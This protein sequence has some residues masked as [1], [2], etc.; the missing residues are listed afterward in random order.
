M[1][2]GEIMLGAIAEAVFGYVIDRYGDKLGELVYD[3]LGRVPTKKAF[4]KALGEAF[5][6]FEQQYPE[7]VAEHFDASFFQREGAPIL[8]QFLIRDGHPDPIELAACWADSLSIQ[9]G[10]HRTIYTRDLESVAADFLDLLAHYLKAQPALRKLNDSRVFEQLARDVQ[11]IRNQLKAE[12]AT[13][14]TRLD[15]LRW[16]IARNSYIDSRGTFQTQ[17]QVQVKLD[18]VYVSLRAQ[19]EASPD[20]ASLYL[21]WCLLPSDPW[22]VA[23]DP[24]MVDTHTLKYLRNLLVHNPSD[25]FDIVASSKSLKQVFT[26]Q[27]KQIDKPEYLEKIWQFLSENRWSKPGE[28]LELGQAVNLRDRLIILGDPGSGKTTL[29]RYL[30]L[31]HAQALYDGYREASPKFGIV[32][33]PILIRI[34]EYTEESTWKNLA[35][36]DFLARC[37]ALHECPSH[38]LADL[39]QTELNKGQCLILLDGLDEIVNADDRRGVVERIEDF[40][41]RY[42]DRGNHF[43]I[44]SRIAGYTS[45]PLSEPFAR[46]TILDMNEEQIRSFLAGWC[47]AVEDAQTPD[48]P[49]QERRKIAQREINGIMMA[50][51]RNQGVRRLASNPLLLRT[52]ALI[53]RTGAQLPQKRIE[54]Y[55]LAVD[56][57]ARTWRTAQGVPESA[58]VKDE[59][60]TPMM[61]KLAYWLHAKKPTGIATEREVTQ[62]L[63]EE[64]ARINELKWDADD[65]SPKITGEIKKFLRDVREHTGLLVERGPNQYGFMHL[66]FEEYYAA[67]YLIARSSTRARRIRSHLHDPRWEEPIL[68]A[69]GFVGLEYQADASA[70]LEAAIL[71][72]GEEVEEQEFT[73]SPYEDLLERDYLFVLRCLGD[74]I[75][76]RPKL[77]QQ[78]VG[79]AANE[80]LHHSGPAKFERYHQALEEKLISL[81]GSQ[82]GNM[83]YSLLIK[84]LQDKEPAV[85]FRAIKSSVLLD[86]QSSVLPT[87]LISM[88]LHDQNASVRRIA[89]HCLPRLAQ[90]TDELLLKLLEA[91]N[92]QD[93]LV[94]CEAA[95]T[96]WQLHQWHLARTIITTLLNAQLEYYKEDRNKIDPEYFLFIESVWNSLDFTASEAVS[97][98]LGLLHDSEA[99]LRERAALLLKQL[100]PEAVPNEVIQ[101][102]YTALTDTDFRVRLRAAESLTYLGNTSNEVVSVLLDTLSNEKNIDMLFPAIEALKQLQPV[103]DE[104]EATLLNLLKKRGVLIAHNDHDDVD[105]AFVEKVYATLGTLGNVSPATIAALTTAIHNDSL[106]FSQVAAQSL[107]CLSQKYPEALYALLQALDDQHAYVRSLAAQALGMIESNHV[108]QQAIMALLDALLDTNIEVQH[109]AV[110]SLAQLD[111]TS[112]EIAATILKSLNTNNWDQLYPAILIL[113]DSTNLRDESMRQL[114]LQK[115]SRASFDKF[116]FNDWIRLGEHFPFTIEIIVGKFVEALKDA[117]FPYEGDAL[118][119]GIWQLVV[120]SKRIDGDE[121]L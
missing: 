46:Y 75:P 80:L 90:V 12:K 59:Y 53:H 77:L 100:N 5:A 6:I 31:K 42:T 8:A 94:R 39:F 33:F 2:I 23:V 109:H 84:A 22:K 64:W 116:D 25:A 65:P 111:H 96:L 49:L 4:K 71:A 66:T 76:V 91:L 37:H 120:G 101:A 10:E 47:Q 21:R 67:R 63:G 99:D 54:L 43:V 35:L 95:S 97:A 73:S 18:E 51:Q 40:V 86:P 61:S 19:S 110:K 13:P 103:P 113:L 45:A 32:R 27:V 68:L 79:R 41:R 1:P 52:L 82:A 50:V 81:Q 104:V 83:L 85:R 74:D 92:D 9:H 112:P 102:L 117:R 62:V 58:L 14:G 118:Y 15:Y 105:D 89:V 30:A 11:V 72:R 3:K 56:T 7:W 78:L 108:P 24:D 121:E 55:K 28:I 119:E 69:L 106:P 20:M 88:M 44:T 70:L 34:A 107:G 38:G 36:S 60:L 16:V 48:L 115:L 26:V 57:L 98:L 87:K 114:L 29:L 17:R 93:I